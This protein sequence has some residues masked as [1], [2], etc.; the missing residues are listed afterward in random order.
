MKGI[1][2]GGRRIKIRMNVGSST[3]TQRAQGRQ[4][5]DEGRNG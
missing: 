1:G 3:G 4:T 5:E 2:K